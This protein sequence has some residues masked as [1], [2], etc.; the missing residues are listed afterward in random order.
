MNILLSTL[1]HAYVILSMMM[2][3]DDV[4]N[5]KS[6]HL[7]LPHTCIILI[8]KI[9]YI[10]IYD[11]GTYLLIYFIY[12]YNYIIIFLLLLHHNNRNSMRRISELKTLRV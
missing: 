9:I 8:I 4:H 12:I 6:W 5:H 3:I 7:D 2:M 10:H 11:I 1:I